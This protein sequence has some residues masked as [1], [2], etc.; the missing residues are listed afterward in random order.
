[1]LGFLSKKT[2]G[3]QVG[4]DFM[5]TGVAVVEVA[6]DTQ[7]Y[8]QVR[9]SEFLPAVGASEQ[10]QVLQHWVEQHELKHVPCISLIAKHDVQLFQLE[11]PAVG[12]D[13]L[14]QAV[15]WKIKDMISYDVDKAIIDIFQLPPSSKNPTSFINAVV[16]NEAVVETYVNNI[17]HA[18]LDLQVIDV[19]D[20]VGKNFHAVVNGQTQTIALLQFTEHEGL[21][22]IY[23]DEDLYVARDFKIGLLDIEEAIHEDDESL[24][25]N[26]LLELQRSMDYFE[27]TYA[28][29]SIQSMLIFPQ[30]SGTER[31]ARYLQNYV[32]YDL[33]FAQ[34]ST[35]QQ[36]AMDEHCFAAYCAALRRL[37]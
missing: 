29:G 15:G 25:E 21:M 31:M 5:P 20:L 34:I 37:N 14:H 32:N 12:D 13:E 8:G 10:S 6:T 30:T 24:Y 1:M 23:Q 11:K 19:H 2:K 9:H 33:D 7:N 18:G 27:S 35:R 17:R 4:V 36:Q 28:L 3:V 16:A 26:L 22:T